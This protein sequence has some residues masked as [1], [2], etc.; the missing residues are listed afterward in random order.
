MFFYFLTLK[1]PV[2]LFHTIIDVDECAEGQSVCD[3]KCINTA[4]SY[5]CV[6]FDGYHGSAE[7][8]KGM[9]Y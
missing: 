3:F 5:S 9:T 4:G 8:C 1:T 2:L 7:D 6:C